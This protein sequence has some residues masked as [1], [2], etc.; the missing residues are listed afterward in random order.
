MKES[1]PCFQGLDHVGIIVSDAPGFIS[2]LDGLGMP[3]VSEIEV[4]GRVL[5]RFVDAGPVQLV[6]LDIIDDQ[7]R[8]ER[9]GDR[10]AVIEHIAIS[11]RDLL[12][13]TGDIAALGI[14]V[15]PPGPQ[16]TS[17]DA[18]SCWS[19]PDTSGGVLLQFVQ[20]K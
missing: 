14:E 5:A 1:A 3:V 12:S 20:R 11:T 10:T 8:S 15:R 19:L 2:L 16:P 13:A 17:R 4:P 18:F 6:V 9:L 7:E